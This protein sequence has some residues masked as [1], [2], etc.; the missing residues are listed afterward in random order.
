MTN[1]INNY[2]NNPRNYVQ[3]QRQNNAPASKGAAS[4]VSTVMNS[5]DTDKLVKPLDG[6]GHLVNGSLINMPKE[7]VRDT[8]YTTK[9]LADGA[10]GKANDHQLGK[11][12]DLGLKLGGV[13]IAT[14]LMTKKST[15]KTKAMEFIGFGAFLASMALWPKVALEIPARLIHGFNFRKQYID[16]QGRKKY[17]SQDPNYIPFDLYKGDKKSEDLDVIG[18][19]AGIRRDIPNRHEAVKEHMRKVSV[20]NNTLWMLTAGI[21]T[22]LMTALACNKAEGLLTDPLEKRGNKKANADIDQ[23]VDYTGASYKR[24]KEDGSLDD[25][26]AEEMSADKKAAFEK[27]VLH[28]NESAPT[29][30][31]TLVNKLKGKVI[32]SEDVN[33]LADTLADGFDAE[34]QDAAKDDINNLIARDRYITNSASADKLAKSIHNVIKASDAD[35]AGKM[36]EEKIG[37][38]VSEGILRGAVKDMMTNVADTVLAKEANA[39]N[40]NHGF[41]ADNL[42]SKND[43]NG[44]NFFDVAP[45][46]ENMTPEERLAHNIKSIVLKVNNSNP[47]ED[48][49]SGM[50][51][52]EQNNKTAYDKVY[53][54]LEQKSK[55]IAHDFYQGN[56]GLTG[57]RENFVRESVSKLYKQEA[58]KDMAHKKMFT[59]IGRILSD[60]AK[61][62]KGYILSEDAAKTITN[63][64]K[65]MRKY[66]AVDKVLN[67]A[68]HFK[69]EKANETIIA[70][71]WDA[72]SK[73]FV[74]EL[75]LTDKEISLASKNKDYSNKLLSKKLEAVCSNEESYN[76]FITKLA[77]KMA[78]LDEKLDTPNNGSNDC[79]MSKL[80]GGI[81]ANCDRAATELGNNGM[82]NLARKMNGGAGSLKNAKIERINSR[83]NGV[84]SSYAR[85]IQTAEFFHRADAYTKAVNQPGFD[86]KKAVTDYGF[87]K[88]A[89]T[90]KKLIEDGKKLLLN[91]HTSEYYNKM[92]LGNN[93]NYYQQLMIS[94]FRPTPTGNYGDDWAET[95]RKTF[96]K[97]DEIKINGEAPRR[98]GE[99]RKGLGLKLKN[100]MNELYNNLGTIFR[101]IKKG[102]NNSKEN[103][104]YSMIE[105]IM[106]KGDCLRDA[107]DAPKANDVFDLLG[108]TTNDFFHDTI[109]QVSNS[110]KWMKTFAPIL[111]GTFLATVAAQF[112]FG[113]KDPDIKA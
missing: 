44:F 16:E 84:R 66:N 61:D 91:A 28:I 79:M 29:Q 87:T 98:V 94:I 73:M 23:I 27:N 43:I 64:A 45:G 60:D 104:D 21:A 89:D 83:I 8:V 106:V 24:I 5:L 19:R 51:A 41:I 25:V 34:V 110:K 52:L 97:L 54:A 12:N 49:I 56:I 103:N 92:G 81:G 35:L 37:K 99:G 101:D 26:K 68:A 65:E 77:T 88:N 85:L 30:T 38:A 72:V 62:S 47:Q 109:K 90:N 74:K 82:N 67:D 39:A 32:T 9:A 112:F 17:V 3:T 111:G 20:Q 76:N 86:M 108:K 4:T 105:K 50:S 95:S 46:T 6:K 2:L 15:P 22:P 69:V 107:H 53:G 1:L 96:G 113:K 100:Q 31:E 93:R 48:F 7:M 33:K 63:A 14:Y 55:E 75:G 71:S 40:F 42:R 78:E 10:R 70:N 58:P 18:D 80:E 11:L 13:A 57:G 59:Q 36:T 102:T